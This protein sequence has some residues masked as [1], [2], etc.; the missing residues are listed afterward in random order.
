MAARSAP[1]KPRKRAAGKSSNGS[2]P[3]AKSSA[4]RP[5]RS[6]NSRATSASPAKQA[7]ATAKQ[8]AAA[9]V[10]D[11]V[12]GAGESAAEVAKKARG[13][14]LAAGAAAAGLA[15]GVALGATRRTKGRRMFGPRPRVL[16]VPV[17]PKSG[18]LKTMELLRD[19]AKQL[20]SAT[21]RMAGT[22]SDVHAI[23]EQLDGAG[24]RSPVEVV[25]DGLTHRRGAGRRDG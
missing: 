6:G 2:A 14:M 22:A 11:G 1:S 15:G 10:G 19:S 13:P 21:S 23:R 16:G 8:Q 3:K 17:G 7:T 4:S 24:G 18:A 12:K 9:S 25:L 5:K 20:N